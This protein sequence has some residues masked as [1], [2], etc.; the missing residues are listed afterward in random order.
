MRI[1]LHS[2]RNFNPRPVKFHCVTPQDLYTNRILGSFFRNILFFHIIT[3]AVADILNKRV[4]KQNPQAK[5]KFFQSVV[6]ALFDNR[7]NNQRG[8]PKMLVFKGL[9]FREFGQNAEK[10]FCIHNFI[11]MCCFLPYFRA[12]ITMCAWRCFLVRPF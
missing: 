7:Q 5:D 4:R 6:Y 2:R 11:K 10:T 9:S 3:P 8:K 12:I 1:F